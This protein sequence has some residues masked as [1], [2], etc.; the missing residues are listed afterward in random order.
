[1][2]YNLSCLLIII[3]SFCIQFEVNGQDPVKLKRLSAP[4][5]FDGYP[6]E[7]SWDGLNYF[8][9]TMNKPVFGNEPSEKTEVMIAYD[10]T[11]LWAG[12]RL[13]M[14][15]AKKI[16]DV[17]KKRDQ[18]VFFY[19]F[20]GMLIDGYNDN[21]NAM[22]FC[23]TPSGLMTDFA[24]MNDFAGTSANM[25]WNTFWDVKTSRDDKGWYVEMRI[26]FSS[27]RFKPDENNITTIGLSLTRFISLNNE[28]DTYPAIDPKYGQVGS[29]K[30]SLASTVQ[31]EGIKPSNPVYISP[32]VIGGFS[33][34]NVLNTEADQY[35]RKDNIDYNAGLDIKYNIKNNLTLDVTVNTDFAQVEA[36]NAQ[37]N[38]TRYS[39]FFPEKRMFFQE[40][41]SLFSFKLN[42]S[43]DN[44]FYSRNIG[45]ANGNQTKIL[46]GVRLAGR[47]GK[48][49]L[50]FL[51]MQTQ[52]QNTVPSENFGVLRM[53]RRVINDNSFIGGILTSRLGMNGKQNY[54]YG[55]DGIFRVFGD[56]YIDVKWSQTYDSE[57][58]NK[59]LS[60][61]PSFFMA[62]WERRSEKGFA[63]NL[64]YAYAGSNFNPRSGYVQRKAIQGLEGELLYG[65]IPGTKSKWLLDYMVRLSAERYTRLE[66][67]GLESLSVSPS[68]NFTTKNS[69]GAT[70]MVN[71]I[72]EGIQRDFSI[73]DSISIKSGNYTQRSFSTS[74]N[75]PQVK[76]LYI[77]LNIKGGEYYDGRKFS[78][79]LSP[80]YNLSPS[81]QL[82]AGYSFDAI[83]FPDRVKFNTLNVHIFNTR[84]VYMLNT[85]LSASVL[86]QYINTTDKF[87]TNFRLRYNPREGNDFYLVYNDLRGLINN[88]EIPAEPA[89]YTKTIIAKYTHTFRL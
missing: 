33:R 57:L 20:F 14:K 9:F 82:S 58:E 52:E 13:Y 36:D 86:V 5:E 34:N 47:V 79:S 39:L 78:Y 18:S 2:K 45:I 40:R 73:S 60:I 76:R 53:R 8:P 12:A 46:G 80:A 19:D 49:D 17:S 50:G 88:Y 83:R 66:D 81:V 31:F 64:K 23:T 4:V 16:L 63:Y 32:Y 7:A 41:S 77:S 65:W 26:P 74:F 38:L 25:S 10:D 48:W 89:F 29:N 24:V 61:D 69:L 55:I 44:L 37:V 42:G 62:S 70:F 71:Y 43:S 21:E 35:Q 15:D 59:M 75:T 56:D 85:K 11:Y 1:M 30:P 3:I 87:T 27:L 28:K 51:D 67:G 68:F 6:F 54:A 22:V 84:I 72:E